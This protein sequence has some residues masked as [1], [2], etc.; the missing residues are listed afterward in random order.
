[1]GVTNL[2]AQNCDIPTNVNTSNVSNFFRNF[3]LGF[4]YISSSL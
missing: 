2:I 3:K 4:R 1:M